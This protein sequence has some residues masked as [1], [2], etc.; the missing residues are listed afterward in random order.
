M[1]H[2][3][4]LVPEIDKE[5]QLGPTPYLPAMEWESHPSNEK[6]E[7]PRQIYEQGLV[8]SWTR[9]NTSGKGNQRQSQ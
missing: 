3:S 5:V 9:T 2:P 4:L 7:A 8:T 1:L 6:M